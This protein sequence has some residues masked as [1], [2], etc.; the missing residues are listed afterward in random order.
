MLA[1]F[2]AFHLSPCSRWASRA[3]LNS[4]S[5]GSWREWEPARSTYKSLW[6]ED[7]VCPWDGGDYASSKA[8]PDDAT[9]SSRLRKLF[10]WLRGDYEREG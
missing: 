7:A 9:G 8:K 6:K 3:N 10:K 2:R 5:D 4:S 1:K